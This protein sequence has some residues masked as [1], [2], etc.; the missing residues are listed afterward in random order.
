MGLRRKLICIQDFLMVS[1]HGG[2]RLASVRSC[3]KTMSREFLGFWGKT[4][5]VLQACY[6]CEGSSN[7]VYFL[8]ASCTQ[9][10]SSGP[11]LSMA[12]ALMQICFY[13]LAGNK[14]VSRSVSPGVI[15]IK[16]TF[17]FIHILC[18]VYIISI[19]VR[20]STDKAPPDALT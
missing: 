9:D 3:R 11:S 4:N 14:H 18:V 7:G 12:A 19:L 8:G 17:A 16:P 15:R 1:G 6:E 5:E 20:K 10:L 2:P 13:L